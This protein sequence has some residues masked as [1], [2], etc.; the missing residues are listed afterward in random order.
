MKVYTDNLEIDFRQENKIFHENFG[1][2]FIPEEQHSDENSDEI[3]SDEEWNDAA[4]LKDS[5][6]MPVTIKSTFVK[7]TIVKF[8]SQKSPSSKPHHPL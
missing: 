5:I 2:S 1:E 3:Q 4:E 6:A 8:Y 7:I